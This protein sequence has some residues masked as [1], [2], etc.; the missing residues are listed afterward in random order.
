MKNTFV[1]TEAFNCAPILNVSLRTYL[2]YHTVPVNVF[3]TLADWNGLDESLRL[4]PQVVFNPVVDTDIEQKFKQ[5][6]AGTAVIFAN[7]FAGKIQGASYTHVIHFD[8]D[9]VFKKESLSLLEAAFDEGYDIAGSRRCYVN[10]PAD[11]VVKPGT[12][13]AISTY[14]FGMR[15]ATIPHYDF[16]YFVLMCQGA[17]NPIHTDNF[18]FFDGVTHAALSTGAKI[19]FL[20]FDLVGGQNEHGK[21]NNK[22]PTNMHMDCG[23]HLIHFGGVGSGYAYYNKLSSPVASYG[24]WATGRWALFAKVF[25]LDDFVTVGSPAI[26]KSDGRWV[27][28][29]YDDNIYTQLEQDLQK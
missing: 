18:D 27:Y 17:A 14:F 4:N 21:K 24:E 2:K 19:K 16:N 12:P 3:G 10:N 5:G 29:N 1:F 28:G 23:E 13:D 20:D 22:Y 26:Y 9:V 7:V 15:I 25:G 11:I 8:S 6:H